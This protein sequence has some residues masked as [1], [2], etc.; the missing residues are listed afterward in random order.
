[1]A[2]LI[3]LEELSTLATGSPDTIES[4]DALAIMV[5]SMASSLVRD[6]AGHPE[7]TKSGETMA[8]FRARL[9]CLLVA[10]RSYNNTDQEVQSGISGGPS[11]RV[12]DEAAA[13]LRLTEA[14]KAE[15]EGMRGDPTEG[16]S[17]LWVLKTTRGPVEDQSLTLLDYPFGGPIAY[18]DDSEAYL[19]QPATP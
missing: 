18:G 15:L 1:M 17:G 16:V 13:G 3:T 12:L 5:M 6:T 11:A 14:E 10:K 9:I 4:D 19:F 7:W 8:P 2:D